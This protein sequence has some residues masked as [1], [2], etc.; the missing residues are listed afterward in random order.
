M[1]FRSSLVCFVHFLRF[2]SG[3]ST[4]SLVFFLQFHSRNV[5]IF[6]IKV[7]EENSKKLKKIQKIETKKNPKKISKKNQKSFVFSNFGQNVS[8]AIFLILNNKQRGTAV[9]TSFYPSLKTKALPL[10]LICLYKK[11]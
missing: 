7:L 8:F 5:I 2:R 4:R 11:S 3:A 9:D 6:I 1:L 10:P